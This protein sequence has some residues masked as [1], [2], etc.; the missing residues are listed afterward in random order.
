[1]YDMLQFLLFYIEN[2]A[3]IVFCLEGQT[4]PQP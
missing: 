2:L 4:H 1:M 3:S